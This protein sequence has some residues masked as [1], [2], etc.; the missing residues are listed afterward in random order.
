MGLAYADRV[1][2][3]ITHTKTERAKTVTERD[4]DITICA[5]AQYTRFYYS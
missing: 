4:W 3:Y 1:S 2:L 5:C